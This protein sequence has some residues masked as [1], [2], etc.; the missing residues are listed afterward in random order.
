MNLSIIIPVYN[1]E[2]YLER[3]IVSLQNQDIPK[4]QY[5][6]IIINDGS[7]DNSRDVVLRL[8][9]EYSNI[10]YIEQENKGVSMARNAG[11]DKAQGKYLLFIDPDDYVVPDSLGRILKSATEQKAQL[12]ILG[13][14]YLNADNTVK[15][16]F[17]FPRESTNRYTGI[18]AYHTS[19]KHVATDPDRSW[20]ILFERDFINKAN[21]RYIADIPYLEDGE[22]IARA[23]CIAERCTFD[24][25][26]FYVRT[27]RQGSATNSSLF[28][29]DRAANGFIKAAE[30]L[31]KFQQN[32][33]LSIAQKEFLNQPICKF[34]I[35]PLYS[36]LKNT[37]KFNERVTMLRQKGF[38]KCNLRGCQSVYLREGFFYNISPYCY[39][40]Y[41]LG[42][43]ALV[44]V[45]RRFYKVRRGALA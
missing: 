12:A 38:K 23:F 42:W 28:Y 3:C 43:S 16:E 7:P 10:V 24:G 4:Q 31:F 30:N 33:Q 14:Q 32:P 40:V 19:T 11:I 37:Q 9:Q 29:T 44:S 36:S 2:K 39:V 35:L 45:Q 25:H 8:M 6:I 27:F 17:L 26:A 5:E 34:I 20:A 18:D 13:Y 41:K 21:L 15:K 1:V 22:F